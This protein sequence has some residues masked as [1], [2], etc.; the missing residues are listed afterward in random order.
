MRVL[1]L[2]GGIASIGW[3]VL[4]L[5]EGLGRIVA[6]GVRTFEKPETDKERIPTNAIRRQKRLARRTLR[7][8]VQRMQ[9]VRR[10]LFA[11]GLLD[12]DDRGAL[13]ERHLDP[14]ALRAAGLERLLQPIEFAVVLGHIARHRGFWS[15]SKRDRGANADPD[16]SKM[17]GAIE[18]TRDRLGGRTFGAMLAH[19]TQ[20]D[21]RKRNRAGDY[22]HTP[23]RRDLRD[24]VK[25]LF[26]AQRRLGST[27]ATKELEDVYAPLAFDQRPLQDSEHLLGNCPFEAEQR[28][29]SKRAY[30]FELFRL[31]S[32]LAHTR[33]LGRGWE[34]SLTE[35]EIG[36]I[37][38][39]F[40]SQKS[41]SY[42]SVRKLLDLS[43]DARFADVTPDD[44][45][46]DI[47]A[48]RGQAAAGTSTLRD[49]AGSAWESLRHTPQR[50]DRIAEVLTF[51]ESLATIREGLIEAGV[52]P[53]LLDGIMAAAEA[54][55]L[56]VF[57]GAAHISAKAARAIIPHLRLGIVYSDAC[58]EA[59]YDHAARPV[60]DIN[61]V[62]N[63][64]ARKALG[65]MLKQVRAIMR[66]YGKPDRIHI[67]LARDMG[68]S[69]EERSEITHGIEKR[70]REK[71]REA[72]QFAELVGRPPSGP[73]E[74]LRYELWQEQQQRCLYSD[75]AISPAQLVATDNSVQVDH[76][77][78][79]SR[80]G[81]DSFINK[82]LCLARENQHKRGRTPYEWF[83]GDRPQDWEAFERRVEACK[84]MKGAKK[85]GFYLRRNAAEVEE[86]FRTRNLNDTRYATRLLL[87][88]LK[89]QYPKDDTVYVRARPGSL[90]AKLRRGWGL[91]G[92]KKDAD[93][94]RVEDDRHHALDA[95]VIAAT[96]ES[97]LQGLTRRFQDAEERGSHRDFSALDQPWPGF[98][99][100][101][102]A[103]MRAVFVSREERRRVAG[104]KHDD[105]I[106]QVRVRD[107]R[108]VVF[109]RREVASLKESDLARLKDADRNGAIADAIR[110][111]IAA[112]KPK[113]APP[114]S[115]KGDVIRK[116]RLET[117]DKPAVAVRGGT[118]DRGDMARVDVFRE[119]TAKGKTR[120][121]MVPVYPHQVVACSQPPSRAVV[122]YKAEELWTDVSKLEFAFS[123]WSNSLVEVVKPDGEVILGYFRGLDRGTAAIG[124]AD[125]CSPRAVRAGIGTKTLLRFSKLA[126]D[127]LGRRIPIPQETRTWHGVVCT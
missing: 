112:G 57:K 107:G 95:M 82:T 68:K 22:A 26:A 109:E 21:E 23:L 46:N 91:E 36:R 3:A 97:M 66:V 32:K 77:L 20:A 120:F 106:K 40:G 1:G 72:V 50:L 108:E 12:R 19:D 119:V 110:Q 60:T 104:K 54:G 126:V 8:R 125:Q 63:P 52:E 79:W 48:R 29:T 117:N 81:D 61:D 101:A 76:I 5:D 111:W 62:K 118:A 11:H 99:L 13:G 31:L 14:W 39:D 75:I 116:V 35:D 49:I 25:A 42:K 45:K 102:E 89:R 47:A 115:H 7:R 51:R 93:G 88:M 43:P 80:F 33:L 90:T 86:R 123:L 114:R 87:D 96:T 67:E 103:A 58:A 6:A 17:L 38:A 56:A 18:A 83:S 65:E 74:L 37:T 84:E 122:A 10:L 30:S 94:N 2:D 98:R 92:L 105:T 34:R 16:T 100:D 78:P 53:P 64:V 15:N 113:D 9:Q 69:A 85:R 44:E 24:E 70:N 41:I 73:E 28:R 59:G 121:H 4:D 124:I 55:K 27:F 71:D 127:R